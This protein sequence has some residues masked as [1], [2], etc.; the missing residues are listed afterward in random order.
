MQYSAVSTVLVS[1]GTVLGFPDPGNRTQ[2]YMLDDNV[3]TAIPLI[4]KLCRKYRAKDLKKIGQQTIKMK[5]LYLITIWAYHKFLNREYLLC[6]FW[7]VGLYTPHFNS[8]HN[9]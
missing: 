4:G 7:Y 1:N 9:R 8:A 2:Q 6:R 5:L 3:Q